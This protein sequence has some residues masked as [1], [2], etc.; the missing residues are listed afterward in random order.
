MGTYMGD[1]LHPDVTLPLVHQMHDEIAGEVEAT[2]QSMTENLV[3]ENFENRVRERLIPFCEER[4]HWTYQSLAQ[5]FSLGD[6]VRMTVHPGG[7]AVLI[8]GVGLTQDHFDGYTWTGRSLRLDSRNPAAG[9]R[10]TVSY[11][12]GRTET[13]S[14]KH[15]EVSIRLEEEVGICDSIAFE[16]IPIDPEDGI[17]PVFIDRSAA[18]QQ[19]YNI[20][21][22]PAGKGMH[23]I[24]L[25]RDADGKYRK[26]MGK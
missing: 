20:Y 26:I 4:P 1:F 16:N 24:R 12:G 22:M 25:V 7:N 19:S 6:V 11:P 15:A 14:Y 3:Y 21:G 8:N 10:M 18:P 9:W 13:F 2:F 17:Q 23:G 5:A